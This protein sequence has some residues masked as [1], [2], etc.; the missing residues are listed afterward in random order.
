MKCCEILLDLFRREVSTGEPFL[1]AALK[2][3][4][5][6]FARKTPAARLR[7]CKEGVDFG[8]R[9][10]HRRSRAGA[11]GWLPCF[12]AVWGVLI[13][14][15][16]RCLQYGRASNAVVILGILRAKSSLGG[17][18]GKSTDP[19]GPDCGILYGLR[20]QPRNK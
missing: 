10:G 20:L 15:D 4:G 6:P 3:S 18:A 12:Q 7:L 19:K 17:T 13:H 14:R 2:G 16:F 9:G 5:E 11:G 1:C 8:H